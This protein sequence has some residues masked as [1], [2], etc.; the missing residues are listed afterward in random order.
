MSDTNAVRTPRDD[1]RLALAGRWPGRMLR[2]EL[3][4]DDGFVRDFV[5]LEGEA[6]PWSARHAVLRRLHHDLVAVQFSA[7]WGSPDQPDADDAVYLLEQWQTETDL[8]VFALM[9]GPFSAAAK[10]WSWEGALRR[11]TAPGRAELEMMAE[12]TVELAEQARSLAARGADGILIGDDIAYRRSAYINPAS[13]R[14]SYFPFLTLLVESIHAIGLPA[15]FHSDGNLWGVLDD[16]L[17]AGIDGL[18]GMEPGAGMSLAGVREKAGPDL[19]LW[20]NVDVGWLS[21]PPPAEEIAGRVAQ[22]LQP[23]AGTPVILGTSGGLMA[24]LPGANVEALFRS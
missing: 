22:L 5:G 8:F 9:D 6:V 24:G 20:G 3:V 18:Q 2:G 14:K 16:L 1:V 10:A 21:Q 23:L 12:A 19:C 7:G 13:L 11:L 17:A 15:V 4:I